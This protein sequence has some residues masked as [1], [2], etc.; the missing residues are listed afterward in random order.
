M[1]FRKKEEAEKAKRERQTEINREKEEELKNGR[2]VV[3]YSGTES[4]LR[5]MAEG[6][7][8]DQIRKICNFF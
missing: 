2:I 1:A 6:E 4:V 8:E 5:I 3:R 7:N